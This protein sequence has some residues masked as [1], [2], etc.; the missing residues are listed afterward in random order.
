MATD[1][2]RSGELARL[3]GVSADTLHHY[4]RMG[5]LPAP[6][7]LDNGYREYPADALGRI[8]LIRRALGIGFTL[9]ELASLL[10]T[11]DSGEAPCKRVKRMAQAKLDDIEQRLYDLTI[12]RDQ[13]KQLVADWDLKLSQTPNGE[14][15]LLLEGL[16]E[17]PEAS[18]SRRKPPRPKELHS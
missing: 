6:N 9:A 2:Y 18:G 1:T 5:V 3:A 15:A 16:P 7:R 8:T 12:L 14:Q 13:L 11:R 10:A 4:E 17:L